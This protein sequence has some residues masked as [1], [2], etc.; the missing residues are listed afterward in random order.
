MSL[1]KGHGLEAVG[2]APPAFP[3]IQLGDDLDADAP[4][5]DTTAVMT[6]LDLVVTA[7]TAAAH[8]AG[9]LAVPVWLALSAIADWRWL[10]GRDDS[11]WYPTLRLF[12]QR[13][14]GEWE[15]VFQRMARALET[16]DVR[17]GTGAVLA[18]VGP[19]E[20]IDKLTVLA[21]KAERIRDPAGLAHVRAAL[22]ALEAV[23]ARAVVDSPAVAELTKALRSVNEELWEVEDALRLCEQAGDFGPRFVELARSVYKRNDERARL[24]RQIDELL[25]AAFCEQKVYPDY[26]EAAPR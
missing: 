10:R 18:P 9:A 19:G 22:T 1:Q 3:L 13:T 16:R 11:P 7:D 14:L 25:G 15:D 26:E 24:K 8:L 20:L 17:G 2:A 23:R 5:L 6:Q 12:R 21:I 4:F